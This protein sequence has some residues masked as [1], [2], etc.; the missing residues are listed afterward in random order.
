MNIL[1]TLFALER[2]LVAAGV[3]PLSAYWRRECECFY[4]HPTARVLVEMVGRGGDKSRTSV[5]MAIAEVL[6][7]EFNIPPGEHHYFAHVSENRDEA[8]KTLAVLAR[9]LEILR[10]PFERTGD[11]IELEQLPRGFK[12]LSCRIGAVSGFRCIGW[13]ADECAKWNSEGVDPSAEVI[14]SIR[15]MTITHPEARGRMISSPMATMGTFYETWSLGD[16]EDQVTG[17]ASSWKANPGAITEQQAHKLERREQYFRREYQAI[18]TGNINS[19]WTPELIDSLFIKDLGELRPITNRVAVIDPSSGASDTFACCLAGWHIRKM[20]ERDMYLHDQVFHPTLKRMVDRTIRDSSGHPILNPA[21]VNNKPFFLISAIGGW[22]G[23]FARRISSEQIVGTISGNAHDVGVTEVISDQRESYLL[24][25]A[26]SRYDMRFHA[27]PWS[28]SSKPLAVEWVTRLMMDGALKIQEH[29]AMRRQLLS[30][31]TRIM[32]SGQETFAGRAGGH[33]DFVALLLTAALGDLNGH[34][35]GSPTQLPGA[36][37][38]TRTDR[39]PGDYLN[40]M[41]QSHH[42]ERC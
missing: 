21:W 2:G 6:A 20:P 4:S 5:M 37:G 42:E 12:V 13:T 35:R 8:A 30:F 26:F 10:V 15:A 3:H 9:Y 38:A 14:A 16:S 36:N 17:Q 41:T 39:G 1:D 22:D 25:S 23:A 34:F 18:A 24:E 11:T 33:D 40:T 7:G 28:A 27:I 19:T 31:E 32:P 29:A